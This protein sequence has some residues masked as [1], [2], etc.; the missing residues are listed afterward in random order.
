M[1]IPIEEK[2]KEAARRMKL[3]HFPKN[4]ITQFLNDN[5]VV[6]SEEP[7]GAYYWADEEQKA[8]IKKAA[9]QNLLVYAGVRSYTNIGTMDAFFYVSDYYEDWKYETPRPYGDN[10]NHFELI[11][12]VYNYDGGFTDIGSIIVKIARAGGL[13]RVF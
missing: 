7:V 12:Y 1:T 11:S 4:I 3:M 8:I 2:K 5:I 10:K 13:V 9:E 6:L